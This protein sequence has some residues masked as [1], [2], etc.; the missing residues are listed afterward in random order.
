MRYV[1]LYGLSLVAW[2]IV[3]CIRIKAIEYEDGCLLGFCAMR[4]G[5][6]LLTLQMCCCL[7]HQGNV[8]EIRQL[9]LNYVFNSKS[10]SDLKN[11][12]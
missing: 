8:K 9:T 3:K 12:I 6:S 7:H 11:G 1:D 4:S 10:F 2:Q 5:R